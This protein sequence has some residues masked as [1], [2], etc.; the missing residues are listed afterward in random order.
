MGVDRRHNVWAALVALLLL[1]LT[2]LPLLAQ[3]GLAAETVSEWDQTASRAE[4]ALKSGLASSDAFEILR[5]ELAQQRAA[6][7]AIVNAG[8]V[9]TR[10]LQAQ[11]DVLGPAP[12]KDQTEAAPRAA[13]RAEL[14]TALAK[15]EEPVMVARQAYARANVLIEEIDRLVRAR[16]ASDLL[17]RRPSPLSP[18]S[19]STAWSELQLYVTKI[20]VDTR[21]NLSARGVIDTY[22]T[23]QVYPAALLALAGLVL[24][25]TIGH[26]GL[27]RLERRISGTAGSSRLLFNAAAVH[28]LRLVFSAVGAAM[29]L[30]AYV[31]LDIGPTMAQSISGAV[32]ASATIFV[33]ANWLGNILFA[34]NQPAI[35]LVGLSDALARS[36]YWLGMAFAGALSV[37]AMV[38]GAGDDF[39][40]S[41][42][43]LSV[44]EG[45]SIV[46]S[47]IVL[48]GLARV[49]LAIAAEQRHGA[50]APEDDHLPAAGFLEFMA[51]VMQLLAL[52]SLVAGAIGYVP[53]A[54]AGLAPIML[55][56]VLFGLVY[57]IHH[58]ALVP[59]RVTLGGGSSGVAVV[60]AL[61]GLALVLVS[62]P[63]LALIW[64]A[65]LAELSEAWRV[66]VNG[67]DLGG[68]R[69][70]PKILLVLFGTFLAGLFLTRWLQ[71]VVDRVVLP[72][73]RIDRGGRN[74]IRTGLGYVGIILSSLL[75]ISAAG[76]DLSN[77]AIIAGALSLGVG[78]GMQAIVS[79][80][81][82]GIILLIERPIKEG[83]W[84]EVSGFSGIVRKIAVRSTR[85][86]T[87]DRHDVIIPNADLIA[88]T[89][90]NMT[91][92]S[93]TGRMIVPI[94]IAYGSDVA[95]AKQ[96]ILDIA[97]AHPAILDEPVPQVFF[98]RLGNSALEFELRC[99]LEDVGT[100]IS[101]RS[102][103][104]YSLYAAFERE[105]IEIPFA[106]SD[107]TI[108]N[109]DDILAALGGRRAS[110]TAT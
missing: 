70:S 110:P 67:V 23:D 68:V 108:R 76:L 6:A 92:S 89:V 40:F 15:A 48:G 10:A 93:Q 41:P 24:P 74:A 13:R 7:E 56:F 84:I 35:R 43:T 45:L 95:K 90:K 36:S 63:L 55:S 30:A 73:T 12:G 96:V 47:S 54:R 22:L 34:P 77:L 98:M 31:I 1:L 103:V 79:N 53:G 107:V 81:V 44:I 25:L 3:Q 64:G 66:V 17:E 106:Q 87:F 16:N 94:G 38:D 85:I 52:A 69:L 27:V 29:L 50:P 33:V 42:Q 65:R 61:L 4:E 97:R 51:R 104:L 99:F 18:A 60:S 21:Q 83:D 101:T 39:S 78:F 86:E 62:I 49:L 102:D 5:A 11:L 57:V 88:G 19:W 28:L 58:A 100:E 8:H 32:V 72:K 9:E 75:A 26:F 91:L 46:V 2:P 109:L 82:S 80:F 20:V 71:Q 37:E 59:L 105:G 14:T